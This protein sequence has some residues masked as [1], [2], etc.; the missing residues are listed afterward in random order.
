MR[1]FVLLLLSKGAM[2]HGTGAWSDPAHLDATAAY[3]GMRYIQETEH[4]LTMI[5]SDDGLS[6]FKLVGYCEGEDMTTIHFD[7]SPKGGPSDLSGVWA[8][9][10]D[11]SVTIT[12]S[13]GNVWNQLEPTADS[14]LVPAPACDAV[15]VA[16]AATDSPRQ[17]SGGALS[18]S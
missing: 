18:P 15:K 3:A 8:K 10:C 2:A 5:G 16:A 9:A 12:W 13:D 11:G 17:R 14:E 6:W 1:A 7:F 4:V